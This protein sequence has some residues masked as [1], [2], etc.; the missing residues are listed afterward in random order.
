LCLGCL[1]FPFF[2]TPFFY[3]GVFPPF[4]L[5]SDFPDF[6]HRA[7]KIFCPNF[8]FLVPSL[9]MPS[10]GHVPFFNKPPC[11]RRAPV[12]FLFLIF[13][14]PHVSLPFLLFFPVAALGLFGGFQEAFRVAFGV[15]KPVDFCP[16]SQ[17]QRPSGPSWLFMLWTNLL[18]FPPTGPPVFSAPSPSIIISSPPCSFFFCS[19]VKPTFFT[20]PHPPSLSPTR[21][22]VAP[23][24]PSIFPALQAFFLHFFFFFPF[25]GEFFPG[26]LFFFL[27]PFSVPLPFSCSR[28]FPFLNL[29]FDYSPEVFCQTTSLF[30][31]T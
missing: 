12:S 1:R 20:Y 26:V 3:H 10:H 9:R 22:S 17:T 27:P 23:A 18:V 15:L 21:C 14:F 25:T 7:K 5:F 16:T 31:I 19:P 11:C 28:L 24:P 30:F 2:L 6:G 13:L 4:F 8:F 29:F